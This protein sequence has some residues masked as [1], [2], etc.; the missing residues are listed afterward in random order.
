MVRTVGD[1]SHQALGHNHRMLSVIISHDVMACHEGIFLS[2]VVIHVVCTIVA[3][4][5]ID[6]ILR[7][8]I[9]EFAHVHL[10]TGLPIDY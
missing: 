7:L 5:G 4:I 3:A 8:T 10:L 2:I 6:T 9:V 1:S